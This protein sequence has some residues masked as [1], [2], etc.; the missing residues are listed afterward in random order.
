MG[1]LLLGLSD[2][3]C[4]CCRSLGHW[5]SLLNDD[6]LSHSRC[7]LLYRQPLM[8]TAM[9]W[10]SPTT[11]SYT[12]TPNTAEGLAVST[13]QKVRPLLIWIMVGTFFMPFNLQRLLPP[14]RFPL[15]SFPLPLSLPLSTTFFKFTPFNSSTTLLCLDHQS[16]FSTS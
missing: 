7:R 3:C 8:W 1:P 14:S 11:C 9:S 6:W 15:S 16:S 2:F 12:T 4:E 10:L 13:L 5:H